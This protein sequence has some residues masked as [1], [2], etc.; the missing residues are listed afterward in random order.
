[1]VSILQEHR[2]IRKPDSKPKTLNPK[3]QH[4]RSSAAK[5]LRRLVHLKPGKEE[6]S[7]MMSNLTLINFVLYAPGLR[8]E[9]TCR[10]LL[11]YIMKEMIM[12]ALK[13]NP[14]TIKCINQGSILTFVRLQ[15]IYSVGLQAGKDGV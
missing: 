12:G 10:P 11:R 14:L 6:G 2:V 4:L 7:V 9:V 15:V 8:D 3:L 1:M 5:H 13:Q